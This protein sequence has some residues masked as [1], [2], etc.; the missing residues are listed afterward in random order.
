MERQIGTQTIESIDCRWYGLVL[1][2]M[3]RYPLRI[4]LK[5]FA[6][7][8]HRSC[9]EDEVGNVYNAPGLLGG[10]SVL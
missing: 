4:S 8:H 6:D 5:H 10:T 9:H 1:E 7:G 2:A 3:S